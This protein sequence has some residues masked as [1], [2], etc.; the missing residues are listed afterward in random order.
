MGV[1]VRVGLG[2]RVKPKPRQWM[3]D[4]KVKRYGYKEM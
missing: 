1:K 3:V 2:L 4:K